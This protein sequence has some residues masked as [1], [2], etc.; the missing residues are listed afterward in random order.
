MNTLKISLIKFV[1]QPSKMLNNILL[2][3][4]LNQI[5]KFIQFLNKKK[6]F[7]SFLLMTDMLFQI[8]SYGKA[9]ACN[10]GD[11]GSIPGLGRSPGEWNG[12]PL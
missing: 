4:S 12:Y 2:K 11:L 9:S 8:S 10:A 5:N 6:V 3:G 1:I 7:V